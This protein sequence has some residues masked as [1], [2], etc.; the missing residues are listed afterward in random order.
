MIDIFFGIIQG[1][2]EFLPISS[3]GHLVVLSELFKD[4]NFNT[5]EI[6][7]LHLGT[8]FSILIFYIKDIIS[9]FKNRNTFIK[10]LKLLFVGVLPAAAF[11]LFLPISD[12]IDESSS[13][14]V[15]TSFAY[16]FIALVLYFADKLE[17]GNKSILDL[18]LKESLIIGFAQA[19]A[20]L[21]GVSRSG[22]TLSTAL[23]LKLKKTEAIF[24]SLLLGLPTIFGAWLLTFIQSSEPI[25]NSLLLPSVAAFLSGLLAI[26]VLINFTVSSKLNIFSVYCFVMGIISIGTYLVNL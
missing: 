3:S 24:F 5:Y 25:N 6:A 20:L 12:I 17:E 15:I 23:Y 8:F 10:V 4:N 19:V 14:L 21:P 13:I 1:I 2:T 7:F 16:I 26:R 22:I 18:S 9:I 11:G